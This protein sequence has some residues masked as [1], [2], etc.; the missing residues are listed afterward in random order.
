MYCKKLRAQVLLKILMNDVHIGG[1]LLKIWKTSYF[2]FH[3]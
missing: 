2:H 3:E 1:G